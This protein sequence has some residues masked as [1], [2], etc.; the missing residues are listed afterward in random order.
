[1]LIIFQEIKPRTPY[2][3]DDYA[4]AAGLFLDYVMA[5]GRPQQDHT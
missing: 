2:V 5:G 1:M 4:I 3:G